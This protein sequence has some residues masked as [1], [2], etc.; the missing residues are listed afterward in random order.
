MPERRCWP[1][2]VPN[3]RPRSN[4]NQ[5]RLQELRPLV[6]KRTGD[7]RELSGLAR[8]TARASAEALAASMDAARLAPT[9]AMLR[10]VAQQ[11][12]LLDLGQLE[13]LWL[14]LLEMMAVSARVERFEA[15]V[16][17]PQGNESPQ[18]VTRIG[19]FSAVSAGRFLRWLPDSGRFME[20]ARQPSPRLRRHAAALEAASD[21]WVEAPVDPSRGALM[22]ALVQAPAWRE[23][24]EQGGPI[25]YLIIGVAALGL[26]LVLERALA[27]AWS[28]AQVRRQMRQPESARRN[29]PLGRILLAVRHWRHLPPEAL[30]HKLDE[31]VLRE[32]P[33]VR[34]GLPLIGVLAAVAPL[35]GLLGT[36][37]GMIETF[38]SI[39]LF[40]AGDPK[41][42]SGGI[43]EAL[44]TTELGLLAAIPLVLCHGML[45]AQSTRLVQVLDQQS[46]ALVARR[47]ENDECL[48]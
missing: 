28:S 17:T 22:A 4:A 24:I 13:A 10:Q 5:S 9:V 33:K 36:V 34:R 23:R 21:D 46:A 25:G 43:S 19:P 11:P 15:A 48:A 41:L 14:G 2:P 20:L 30:Q 6:E 12:G 39:T 40:G 16:I 8:Q 47:V 3:W 42:M 38:Q 44:V 32:L 29:N 7:L 18:M 1:A 27:L 45:S 31:A 37:A 26:L 35:L